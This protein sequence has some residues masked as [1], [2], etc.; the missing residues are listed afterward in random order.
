MNSPLS[1]YLVKRL[2]LGLVTLF[3]I[4][5][6]SYLLM[7]LAPGNAA[8]SSVFGNGGGESAGAPGM[9]ESD[10]ANFGTSQAVEKQL[11]LDKPVWLG[12]ALWLG[13]AVRGDFGSSVEVGKGR[14][15]VELVLERLPVTLK[16]NFFAILATYLLAIPLGI[17]SAVSSNAKMD[18]AVTLFLF[19]LYALPVLFTALMLR[20]LFC[21]GGMFP[22]FP[23]RG[24]TPDITPHMSTWAILGRTAMH[25]I[26]PVFCLS[27]GGFAVIA[28]FTRA[29]MLDVI[30]QE[31]I[32]TARA[33]GVPEGAIVFRH[34]F[35]NALI[36]MI[37]LFA[38]ILPGLVGGSILIEYIFDIP[39]MGQLS[40]D[41]LNSRDIPLMMGLFAF[42]GFLTL[43]GILLA[44]ILYVAADPRISFRSAGK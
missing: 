14:P 44:D 34:A 37:T 4:L 18:R 16:L 19:F 42:S 31:Y 2:F 28:R 12:F 6:A 7:R 13:D 33:K 43:A 23:L 8:R 15:V 5:L 30:R 35:R 17:Q 24:L 25:Y 20:A 38:G 36:L 29:G 22:V 11:N 40:M 32:R 27:Y 41:A 9:M 3:V 26:L 21:Q 39:G 10:K 1:Q